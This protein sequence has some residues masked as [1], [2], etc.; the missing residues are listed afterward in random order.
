MQMD[1]DSSFNN[2]LVLGNKFNKKMYQSD[3][4]EY[5]QSRIDLSFPDL[6]IQKSKTF[7]VD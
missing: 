4:K 6:N 3:A 1:Y 5:M 7:K 2:K